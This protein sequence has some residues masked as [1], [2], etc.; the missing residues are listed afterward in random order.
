[1]KL[2]G[3]TLSPYTRRVAISM[4]L[5]GM[6]FEHDGVRV[7]DDPDPVRAH[8]P[9]TRVPTLVLDDGEALVESGA[10]LDDLDQMVGPDRALVPARNPLRRQ[11]MQTVAYGVGIMEKAQWAFYE[12]RFHP[13][14]K[15]HQPWVDHNDAQVV[16]GMEHLDGLADAA[17]DNWLCNTP[18]M[19]QADVT[20]AVAVSFA[21]K[22]RPHIDP[23]EIAPALAAFTARCEATDAFKAFPLPA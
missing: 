15:V 17:G 9:L 13:P 12:P 3:P 14:E 11:V 2:L 10:I 1:M 16:A 6:D 4:R 22:V 20:V 8:N 7:F 21:A 18:D 19:S 23:A 5:L